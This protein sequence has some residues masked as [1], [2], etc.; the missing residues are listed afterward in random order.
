MT[1]VRHALTEQA[2]SLAQ[3]GIPVF[4]CKNRPGQP[5]DKRPDTRHGFLDATAD[6]ELVELGWWGSDQLI[7]V[8]TGTASGISIID[9]DPRNG[10]NVWYCENAHRLVTRTH[11]TR[12]GGKHLLYRHNGLIKNSAGLIAPGVDTRG[13]GG[14]VIW[15]EAHGYPVAN[16]MPLHDL[17]PWPDWLVIPQKMRGVREDVQRRKGAHRGAGD[18][19]IVTRAQI[20]GI[21]N[22]L[23][24]RRE[25]ERNDCLFW[26]ACR[27]G[28]M[29][30]VNPGERQSTL[31]QLFNTALAIG[32][33]PRGAAATINSGL[34]RT[35]GLA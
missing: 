25:G 10:G 22:F 16:R 28:E 14:Y 17:S 1:A 24:S 3:C 4:P 15:W 23:R 35:G 8:P 6:V 33:D 2:L 11:E 5:D 26:A 21:I 27:I 20:I 19:G 13:D 29:N 30:F 31:D 34:S 12:S 32:L 18:T 7:G 9:I